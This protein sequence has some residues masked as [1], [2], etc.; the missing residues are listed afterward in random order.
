MSIYVVTYCLWKMGDKPS[1]DLYCQFATLHRPGKKF[2]IGS[3]TEISVTSFLSDCKA[4]ILYMSG[5]QTHSS[6][7]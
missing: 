1:V 5:L 3:F 2:L 4:E 6:E 7:N